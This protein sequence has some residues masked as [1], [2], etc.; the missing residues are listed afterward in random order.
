MKINIDINEK[1]SDTEVTVHCS[2]LTPKIE[3]V[4]SAIRLSEQNTDEKKLAVSHGDETHIIDISDIVYIE[5]VD[6]RTFVYTCESCFESKNKLYEIE[7][8]LSHTGFL[9]ISK[10]CIVQLK[11]IRSIKS[12]INRKLRLTL[13]NGEQI[14]VSRQYADE[15]KKRLGV[16]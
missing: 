2:E 6:R 5:S 8:R 4:I 3:K 9:R 15:L 13:E 7:E 1:Y 11:Q 14:I 10:A 16:K 12:E